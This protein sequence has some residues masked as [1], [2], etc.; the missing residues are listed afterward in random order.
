[1]QNHEIPEKIMK[2]QEILKL[3][4][5]ISSKETEITTLKE[6]IANYENLLVERLAQSTCFASVAKVNNMEFCFLCN[7]FSK[8][9][10]MANL[11][12]IPW[13]SSKFLNRSVSLNF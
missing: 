10:S 5:Q 9:L 7:N 12:T 6:T 11:T 8:I 13:S 1:M 3:K 4:K 2:F